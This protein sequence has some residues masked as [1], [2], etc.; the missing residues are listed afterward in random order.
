MKHAL[1]RIGSFFRGKLLVVLA[2]LVLGI[3]VFFIFRKQDT[4]PITVRVARGDIAQEVTVT[5]K[6]TAA[7]DAQLSFGRGGRV[8]SAPV[9]VGD[10]VQPGQILAQTDAS[11]L[12]AQLLQAQAQVAA[13]RAKLNELVRGTRPEDLRIKQTE[14]EK[15]QQDLAN[16]YQGVRDAVNT[17][18]ANADDAVRKQTDSIFNDDESNPQLVF[19]VTDSQVE[20]D[21]E[22]GRALAGRE[23][24]TWRLEIDSL[25][26]A[27]TSID[28]DSALVRA[29]SHLN[30]VF[31]FLNDAVDALNAN[32]T[33]PQ[34]TIDGYKASV[35]LARTNVNTTLTSISTQEQLIASQKLIMKRTENE[36]ALKVAGTPSEQIE[37]QQATVAQAEAQVRLIEAQISN[38][39]IR[40]PIAGVVTRQ[41]ARLGEV[42]AAGATL[43]SVISQGAFEIEA[44]IPEVDIGKITAGNPVRITLDAFPGETFF[45]IVSFIDPGETIIDGVVNFKVTIAFSTANQKA[46]SGLTANL[47]IETQKKTGVLVLPQYAIVEKDEGT[48][49][50]IPAQDGSSTDTPVLIGIRSQDGLVEILSGVQEGQEVLNVGVRTTLE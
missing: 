17:A 50:R 35:N 24:R 10:T 6:T 11:E 2:I 15:A 42:A 27:A 30:A 33:L 22:T 16:A 49:V 46:K 9:R 39:T 18:Y 25:S 38:T 48:F 7:D 31:A 14:L 26:A 3:V 8:T 36:L 13:A 44:N 40:S 37:A 28:L 19:P 20:I 41:D 21:A 45:G 4:A 34:A 12:T 23:L 43:I 47:A 29:K 1:A 32:I 5:G